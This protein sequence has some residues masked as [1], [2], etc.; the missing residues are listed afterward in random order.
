MNKNKK[1]QRIWGIGITLLLIMCVPLFGFYVV[2]LLEPIKVW[3]FLALLVFCAL[4]TQS[5]FEDSEDV[6]TRVV[7]F[8]VSI[9][10]LLSFWYFLLRPN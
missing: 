4:S 10:L 9:A 5:L 7:S 3:V 1:S 6:F 8:L 2:A